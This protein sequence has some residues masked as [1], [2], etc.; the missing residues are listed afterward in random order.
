[1]IEGDNA[2][3]RIHAK[4]FIVVCLGLMMVNIDSKDK[5]SCR[6]IVVA[7]CNDSLQ[8]RYALQGQSYTWILFSF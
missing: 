8:K 4:D 3:R 7:S 6:R 2:V 1:M 5:S